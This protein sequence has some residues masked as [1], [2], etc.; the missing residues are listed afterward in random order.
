MP[1]SG[2]CAG[3]IIQAAKYDQAEGDAFKGYLGPDQTSA[4]IGEVRA[5]FNRDK[6][7]VRLLLLLSPT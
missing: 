1:F 2:L 4:D 6:G 7:K 5:R 3:C